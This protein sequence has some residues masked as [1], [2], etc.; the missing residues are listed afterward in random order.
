MLQY[1]A[2][3][4]LLNPHVDL[5]VAEVDQYLRLLVTSRCHFEIESALE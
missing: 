5:V 2:V 1:C 3:E 4:S